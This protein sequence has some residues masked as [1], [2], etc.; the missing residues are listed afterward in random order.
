MCSS[1]P[2]SMPPG[3]PKATPRFRVG[4][5]RFDQAQSD[6]PPV[7][8]HALNRVTIELQFADHSRWGVKPS[9]AQRGKGHRLLTSTTKQLKRQAMLSLNERHE[10]II[11]PP[12]VPIHAPHTRTF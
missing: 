5:L 8:I 9:R 1:H 7:L 2:L 10:R 12:A 11:D 4:M 3:P 6:Q